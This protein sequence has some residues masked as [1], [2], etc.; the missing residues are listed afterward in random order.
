MVTWEEW[1]ENVNKELE[2]L[3]QNQ[4][5]LDSRVDTAFERI[6]KLEGE[7]V[8][9]FFLEKMQIHIVE[10]LRH[11]PKTQQEVMKP[12]PDWAKNH[13]LYR[14]FYEAWQAFEKSGVILPISHGRGHPRT[15]KL[16]LLEDPI[17]KGKKGRNES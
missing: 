10:S 1:A 7:L 11:G 9:S 3:K 12:L 6:N 8:R 14:A 16:N 13:L 17:S 4:K 5:W 15:W 2:A